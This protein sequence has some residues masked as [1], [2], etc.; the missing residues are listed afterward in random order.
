MRG[1]T[2]ERRDE[3][4]RDGGVVGLRNEKQRAVMR[5]KNHA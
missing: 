1:E 3:V 2:V 4:R 5:S